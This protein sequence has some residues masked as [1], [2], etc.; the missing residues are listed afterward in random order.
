MG[1]WLTENEAMA[2]G[3]LGQGPAEIDRGQ[4]AGEGRAV[5]GQAV[6][7]GLART[8]ATGRALG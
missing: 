8:A 5:L 3:I 4:V 7:T 6:T 2:D 1:V